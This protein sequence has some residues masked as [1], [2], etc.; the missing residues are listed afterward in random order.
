M[1]WLYFEKDGWL[2]V[3][4]GNDE[5]TLSGY[6]GVYHTLSME[7]DEKMLDHG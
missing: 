2:S 5:R 3:S 7:G 1:K 6:F 4:F